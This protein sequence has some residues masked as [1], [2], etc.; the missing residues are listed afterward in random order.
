MDPERW[1]RIEELYHAAL[2]QDEGEWETFLGKACA[3]DEALR[4][5]VESLL[6]YEGQVEVFLR[7]PLCR[8]PP[9]IEPKTRGPQSGRK[10]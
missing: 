9:G 6:G 10:S 7:S 3:G 5:E 4:R 8:K 1:K 2:E